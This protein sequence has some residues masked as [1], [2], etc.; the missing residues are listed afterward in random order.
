MAVNTA[1]GAKVYIGSANTDPSNT[2]LTGFQ[3]DTYVEIGE[4]EDL[5]EF[6]D[7]VNNT[8]FTSLNDRRVRKFKTSYDA[9]ELSI[10]AGDDASDAGQAAFIAALASDFDYNFKVTL[11]DEQTVGGTPTE[12]YFAGQVMSDRRNVGNVE[13]VVRRSYTVGINTALFEVAAT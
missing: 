5:G 6:G 9:G 4:V 2:D 8:T 7:A 13:N 3:A 11:S 12:I 10:T 1:A